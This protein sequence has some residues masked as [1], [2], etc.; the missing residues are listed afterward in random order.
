MTGTTGRP[1]NGSADTD[2]RGPERASRAEL[3]EES[4]LRPHEEPHDRSSEESH[5][6]S[7]EESLLR[8]HEEPHDRLSEESR[9]RS[10]DGLHNRRHD[11][12]HDGEE[13]EADFGVRAGVRAIPMGPGSQF[14]SAE[15]AEQLDPGATPSTL[16]RSVRSPLGGS[17]TVTL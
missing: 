2:G 13:G 4:H 14:G 12:F 6:P 5:P 3:R 1:V 15:P 9:L 17:F 7:H 11:G 16:L 8:S 10:H